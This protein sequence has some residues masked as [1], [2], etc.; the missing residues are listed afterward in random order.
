MSR[1][2]ERQRRRDKRLTAAILL[3]REAGYLLTSTA[4]QRLDVDPTR[5]LA[6]RRELLQEALGSAALPQLVSRTR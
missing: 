1:S 4:C 2:D 5:L 3:A 6:L